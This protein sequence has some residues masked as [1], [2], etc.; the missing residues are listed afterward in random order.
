[1]TSEPSD[2]VREGKKNYREPNQGHLHDLSTCQ[3]KMIYSIKTSKSYGNLS[4]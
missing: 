1:M 3:S 2:Y 4:S